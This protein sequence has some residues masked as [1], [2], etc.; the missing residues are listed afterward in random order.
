M[1][2]DLAF[3]IGKQADEENKTIK[4]VLQEK[5]LITEEIEKAIQ[6][7]GSLK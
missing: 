4:Q 1:G 5:G 2:Y 6:F 7:L 3:Q